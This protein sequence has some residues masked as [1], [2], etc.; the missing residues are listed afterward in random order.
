MS[1]GGAIWFRNVQG[2]RSLSLAAEDMNCQLDVRVNRETV[3]S[4]A[5]DAT[6]SRRSVD[7]KLQIGRDVP[8]REGTDKFDMKPAW[9]MNAL[10][11]SHREAIYHGTTIPHSALWQTWKV[12]R[13]S[14]LSPVQSP[15]LWLLLTP[16]AFQLAYQKTMTLRT[17]EAVVDRR[18]KPD[19]L[20]VL[21][22]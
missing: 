14:P 5:T 6:L 4:M 1:E 17:L 11:I 18:K 15:S 22:I 20:G 12:Q 2:G 19:V 9:Q 13:S 8:R 7:E 10:S 21:S 16:S 3:L